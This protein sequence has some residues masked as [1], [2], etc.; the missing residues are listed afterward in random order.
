MSRK[1]PESAHEDRGP[2]SIPACRRHLGP[3]ASGLS[4]DQVEALRDE[5]YSLARCVVMRL[6]ELSAGAVT[7]M[8]AWL[9]NAEREDVE[10]RAAILEFDGNVSPKRALRMAMRSAKKDLA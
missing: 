8:L 9:P 2:L 7:D 1:P 5:L 3:I 10:E 6:E 4:D